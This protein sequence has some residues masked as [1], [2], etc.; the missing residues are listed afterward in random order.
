MEKGGYIYMLTNWKNS[1]LYTGVNSNL[2]LRILQHRS[3]VYKDSFTSRYHLT[4]LV[5]Y[6]IFD[7][8]EMA[9]ARGK[10]IKAGSRK[11]KIDLINSLNPDW[12]DLAS[13][14]IIYKQKDLNN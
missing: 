13:K 8:I 5:Y 10:Q 2:M 11:K 14:F 1:V 7:E 3:G 6:E 4:K 9:I 12:L